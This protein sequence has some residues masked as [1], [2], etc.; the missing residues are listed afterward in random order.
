MLGKPEGK[1]PLGRLRRMWEDN[2]HNSIPERETL[3]KG[4]VRR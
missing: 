2:I 4:N 3:F 1:S